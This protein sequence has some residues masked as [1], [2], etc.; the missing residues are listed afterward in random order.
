[1]MQSMGDKDEI[2]IKELPPWWSNPVYMEPSY[3]EP[4]DDGSRSLQLDQIEAEKQT[5]TIADR[6]VAEIYDHS[7]A[8]HLGRSE[9]TY[10]GWQ[11]DCKVTAKSGIPSRHVMQYF[12]EYVWVDGPHYRVMILPGKGEIKNAKGGEALPDDQNVPVGD[13]I[14][15]P[16][17]RWQRRTWNRPPRNWAHGKHGIK[18]VATPIVVAHLL[19]GPTA[20]AEAI[21]REDLPA[22]HTAGSLLVHA[23]SSLR[24]TGRLVDDGPIVESIRLTGVNWR[25][26]WLNGKFSHAYIDGRQVN[27]NELRRLFK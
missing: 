20:T 17:W 11:C 21:T 5:E 27:L 10:D 6:L 14:E 12:P 9:F 25:A 13:P 1:M 4:V 7:G 23:T 24:A 8:T 16:T 26:Y 3:D 18:E 15:C 2:E 22:R 19:A